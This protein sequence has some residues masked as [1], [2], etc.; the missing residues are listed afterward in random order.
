MEERSPDGVPRFD[1]DPTK[2]A[3]YREEALQYHPVLC[4][5]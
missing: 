2:L 3:R 5:D 1:G 4:G